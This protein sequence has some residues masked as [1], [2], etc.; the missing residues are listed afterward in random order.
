MAKN[1]YICMKGEK[2]YESKCNDYI[3]TPMVAFV[4]WVDALNWLD[5]VKDDKIKYFNYDHGTSLYPE[6][7]KIK[8]GSGSIEFEDTGERYFIRSAWL[9]DDNER[10]DLNEG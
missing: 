7:I 8:Y 2:R 4:S 5:R 3:E 6:E 1:I 9:Y 10:K